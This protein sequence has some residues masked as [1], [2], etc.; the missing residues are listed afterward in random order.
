MQTIHKVPAA[1]NGFVSSA[2]GIIFDTKKHNANLTEAEETLI[3][4]FFDNLKWSANDPTVDLVI[5]GDLM[6]LVDVDNRWA[7]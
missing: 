6:H 4:N 7:Y 2:V 3:D 1:D 5:Y